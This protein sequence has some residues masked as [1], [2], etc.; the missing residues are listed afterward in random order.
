MLEDLKKAASIAKKIRNDAEKLLKPGES[1]YNIAETIETKIIDLGGFPGFPVNISIN[2]IAAHYTPKVNDD[3]K[4][5]DGDVVKFDYGV[6]VNGY[7][8]D[9]AFTVEINDNKYKDLID[10]SKE[11]LDNVRKI[12]KKDL[13]VSKIGEIIDNTIKSKGFKPIYNLSGHRIERYI[14]HAGVS[15][16]NYNNNSKIR[17]SEGTYAVEPFAT[18]G[19]G[20]AEDYTLSGIYSIISDKPI[21]DPNIRRFFMELYKDYNTIPFAYRWL[22]NKYNGK[23]NLNI[24]IEYLKKNGN[25]YEY[26]VL[27][28]QGDGIVTQFET[29][30][31]INNEI[32]DMMS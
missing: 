31:Y 28:E 24:A 22:Y 13:E 26:P 2:N 15:I 20:F 18:N 32:F 25:L 19:A 21:R 7:I 3:K 16:P 5:K 29:T 6:H 11:A 14:L 17:L 10:A 9:T 27:I 8:I 4:I 30:F 1:L 12:I 23:I